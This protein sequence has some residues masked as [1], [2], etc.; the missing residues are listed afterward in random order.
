MSGTAIILAGHG[1]HISANTAGVVW[2]HVDRLRQLGLAD[3]VTACFWKEAPSFSQALDTVLADDVVVIPMFT[4]RGYFT[5]QVLPSEMDLD[6][7]LTARGKRRIHLT[8]AIGQHKRLD[9]IVD[10]RLRDML[11]RCQLPA[12][13]TA[14]AI[15]GHGTRRNRQSRDTAR[16]QAVRIREA[17][18]YG[19]VEAVYLDDE[20]DIPSIY[21]STSAPNIIALPYFVADGSH[22]GIDLP[23]ALGIA[24]SS[25]GA[26][27]QVNGRSVYSCEALGNDEAVFE[28]IL[29]LARDTGLDFQPRATEGAWSGFPLAGRDCLLSQLQTGATLRFGQV[30]V[31]IER[32]WHVDASHSRAIASP[33]ALRQLVR[34]APFRPLAT[35]ADLP[36]GWHVD[37]DSP[38]AA[39]AVLETI[40]PGLVADWAAGRRSKLKTT[41]LPELSQRQ[42]GMFQQIHKLSRAA[43]KATVQKICGSCIRQ[44]TW[45]DE[46]VK[47][48][49]PPCREACNLW[50]STALKRGEL[51]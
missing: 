43:I 49:R 20:P 13:E 17:G 32:V 47:D 42:Q 2:Q 7:A 14:V 50:L 1:S 51:S 23:S 24:D 39:H 12:R 37:L 8:P 3:E 15:I 21:R 48:E 18:N 11:E 10:Q 36:G 35:S 6:G 45:W 27:A 5:A 33:S 16:Q 30:M 4:A 29:A 22:V 31:S 19:E 9:E 26:V 34:E 41:A 46:L 38:A 44:P 25:P 28:V 40:Y